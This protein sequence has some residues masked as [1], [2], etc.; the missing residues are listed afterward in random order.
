MTV[1]PADLFA[2][3]PVD[4]DVIAA[5]IAAGEAQNALIEE[6]EAHLAAAEALRQQ[7]FDLTDRIIGW[8]Q[9]AQL[10]LGSAGASGELDAQSFI[11]LLQEAE[12]LL[13]AHKALPVRSDALDDQRDW[14]LQRGQQAQAILAIVAVSR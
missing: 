10:F 13:L 1:T 5:A 9:A 7:M 6:Q 11:G 3:D 8:S 12:G 2:Q 14:L 4:P